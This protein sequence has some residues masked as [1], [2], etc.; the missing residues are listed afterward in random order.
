MRILIHI[1]LSKRSCTRGDDTLLVSAD[2]EEMVLVCELCPKLPVLAA[3]FIH[4]AAFLCIRPRIMPVHTCHLQ[5][6]IERS[7]TGNGGPVTNVAHAK[8]KWVS[9]A[10]GSV[11]LFTLVEPPSRE[12]LMDQAMSV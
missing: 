5:P 2:C 8:G 7:V 9:V 12:I 1:N 11:S 3:G 10:S 6:C 4:V